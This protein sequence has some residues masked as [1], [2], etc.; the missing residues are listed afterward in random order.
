MKARAAPQSTAWS[1]PCGGD[2]DIGLI[3]CTPSV[4]SP[5]GPRQ[6][7]TGAA[8]RLQ[9][10]TTAPAVGAQEASSAAASA[11]SPRVVLLDARS[12]WRARKARAGSF[13]GVSL[14]AHV[15]RSTPSSQTSGA[16]PAG[17]ASRRG[18]Q[19]AR[20]E[21]ATEGAAAPDAAARGGAAFDA[22]SDW[23]PDGTCRPAGEIAGCLAAGCAPTLAQAFC[24]ERLARGATRRVVAAGELVMTRTCVIET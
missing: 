2:A 1:P 21:A 20:R 19:S 4:A 5:S 8:P 9:H 6:R 18:G 15:P 17:G 22:D 3:S 7:S 16:S 12:C 14:A 10:A 23:G 13:S 24:P 11:S